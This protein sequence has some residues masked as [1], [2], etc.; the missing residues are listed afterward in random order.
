MAVRG[1]SMR[2]ESLRSKRDRLGTVVLTALI[3]GGISIPANAD[4]PPGSTITAVP[5]GGARPATFGEMP[6]LPSGLLSEPRALPTAPLDVLDA[7]I[8]A[9]TDESQTLSERINELK[10][11][12]ERARLELA[13]AQHGWTL[14]D[15]KLKA[16]KAA[17]ANAANDAYMSARELPPQFQSGSLMRDLDLLQPR[18][19]T[20]SESTAYELERAT[21]AEQ[22]A[23]QRLEKA[24]AAEK[25]AKDNL[26]LAV[27]HFQQRDA[28]RLLLK[29]RYDQ[30][31]AELTRLQA[32]EARLREREE[33]KLAADYNPGKSNAGLKAAPAAQA[34][35]RFALSQLGKPYRYAEEGPNFYD[36]SGLVQTAYKPHLLLPRVSKD[37]Y[38]ATSNR[39]ILNFNALLPGDLIFYARDNGDA[40]TIHHVAIYLGDN[41][42]VHATSTGDVVKVSK[43]NF[44]PGGPVDFATR[45]VEAVPEITTR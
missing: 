8:K 20:F 38:Q 4:P 2:R 18:A 3:V 19:K 21:T 34:A 22:E 45:V 33:N 16:A 11:E 42:V 27:T 14:A 26:D 44:G 43:L 41:K 6:L 24:V 25:L 17:A 31:Q 40:R 39:K 35:V 30:M 12:H 10:L 5:D 13:W 9:A 32:E 15:E 37:M 28:A 1:K 23:A 7:Q 29:Q 36:C